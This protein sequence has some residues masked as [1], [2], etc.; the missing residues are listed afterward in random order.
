MRPVNLFAIAPIYGIMAVMN[1]VKP[2]KLVAYSVIAILAS[3]CAVQW[4]ARHY[5]GLTQS[6][7]S[8][9]EFILLLT[10]F[11]PAS[12]IMISFFIDFMGKQYGLRTRHSPYAVI[13]YLFLICMAF[14]IETGHFGRRIPWCVFLCGLVAPIPLCLGLMFL[15]EQAV[16]KRPRDVC[17]EACKDADSR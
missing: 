3:S 9:T 15:K 10:I 8:F 4:A 16:N 17:G 14:Y 2:E 5:F 7:R 1:N 11:L 13:A 6:L 12:V